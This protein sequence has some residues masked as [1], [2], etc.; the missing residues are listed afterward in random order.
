MSDSAN[1][2]ISQQ[3]K[4]G[5]H[6]LED[7]RLLFGCERWRGSMYLGGY[8][9]E[10]LLKARLMRMFGCRHLDALEARLKNRGLL[11]VRS[12]VF[13]HSLLLLL[14][15]TGAEQRLQNDAT[16]WGDF[17]IVNNWIPAWR[18]SVD[19]SNQR[20]AEVFLEAVERV[21]HWLEVNV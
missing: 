14:R 21:C 9:V 4:A 8:A 5:L 7:A 19:Q 3:F 1:Y 10:C 12:T 6:R 2:G 18:Y 13:T 11:S 17:Q 15:L 16:N 20:R